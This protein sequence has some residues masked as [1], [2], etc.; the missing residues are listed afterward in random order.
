MK[1]YAGSTS[2]QRELRLRARRMALLTLRASAG[3]V[4]PPAV[5]CSRCWQ[6]YLTF[7]L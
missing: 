7:H 5:I 1:R 2:R 4:K 6:T 3:N